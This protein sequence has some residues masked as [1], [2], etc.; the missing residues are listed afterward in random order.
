M[1]VTRR[2][3]LQAA[4]GVGLIAGVPHS[5]SRATGMPLHRVVF[6]SHHDQSV[7]FAIEARRQGVEPS[8][9]RGDVAALYV[10]DLMTR[11]RESAIAV[12][13]LTPHS[14][15]FGL[16]LLAETPR[17]RLVFMQE[18]ESGEAYGPATVCKA[19]RSADPAAT[20]RLLCDWPAHD[21]TVA[22]GRSNILLAQDHPF[23]ND[24][25]VAW[26]M[27]PVPA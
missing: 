12:A 2:Q 16:R 7:R 6:D 19:P 4:G 22:R 24:A 18:M 10:R 11:W 14:Q 23:T 26:L 13:G 1:K 9:T 27:A 15:L 5:I 3:L 21:A 17:L 25:L 20:A 8:D